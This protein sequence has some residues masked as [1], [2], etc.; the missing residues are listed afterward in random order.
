[1]SD[2]QACRAT[3]LRKSLEMIRDDAK[4]DAARTV[5]MTPADLGTTRGEMLSQ[6]FAQAQNSLFLLDRLERLERRVQMYDALVDALKALQGY[7]ATLEQLGTS[8]RSE[9]ALITRIESAIT[10]WLREDQ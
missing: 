6:I 4:A 5:Q 1:M 7:V 8:A 2:D 3:T 10:T 9:R